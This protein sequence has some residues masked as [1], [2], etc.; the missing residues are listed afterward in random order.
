MTDLHAALRRAVTDAAE[1]GA[2]E[3]STAL[4]E[5]LRDEAS[6]GPVVFQRLKSRVYRLRLGESSPERRSFV[7]KRFD[8]WLARRNE[9]VA[10]RWLPALGLGDRCPQLYTVAAE[11]SGSW[12]WH[13]YEDIGAGAIDPENPDRP[14]VVAVVELLASL[15]TRAARHALLPG[16]RHICG[17]LGAPYFA[18][19]V[20]D[21]IAVLERLEQRP[22]RDRLLDR[23]YRLRHEQSRRA[24]AIEDLGGPDTL[25]HGDLWTTNTFVAPPLNG[26]GPTARLIDWDHAAVGPAT[27]DLSTF[28]YR[29]APCDRPWILEAY[30]RAVAPSG[31]T[32]PSGPE[33]NGL[34]ETAEY[35]RYANRIIWPAVAL[36]EEG[37]AWGWDTLTEVERWFDAMT[38]VLPL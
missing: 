3:L 25:L 10:R 29:F 4:G 15:H 14:S 21:A 27:Y 22:V 32:L 30:A 31:W 20:R 23:L 33:L 37:A 28:L 19:N 9:L 35:S 7:L 8:P 12:I 36:L 38:P 34:F 2:A 17:D 6:D 5:T 16:C 24:Q 1:P 26:G 11:R 13:V 18:A